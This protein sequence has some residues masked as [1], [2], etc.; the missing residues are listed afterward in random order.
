MVRLLRKIFEVDPLLCRCGAR[1]KVVSVITGPRV[2]DRILHHLQS[3]RCKA[4]DPFEPRAP[5]RPE[6]LSLP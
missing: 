2:I 1:M 3:E 4:Q 5:P 6:A